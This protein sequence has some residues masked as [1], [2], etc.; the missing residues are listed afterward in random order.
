MGGQWRVAR[1]LLFLFFVFF[2]V[3]IDLILFVAEIKWVP[4]S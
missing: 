3:N 2:L 4:L 1:E